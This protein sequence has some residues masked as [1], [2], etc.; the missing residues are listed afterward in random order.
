MN[1]NIKFSIIIPNYNGVQFIESCLKSLTKSLTLAKTDYE[2]IIIDNDSKD[3]SISKINELRNSLK[4]KNCKLKINQ[5]NMGFA[6]AVNQGIKAAKFD[7]ILLC[8]NDLTVDKNYFSLL[9]DAI[10][11]YPDYTTYVGT[12]LNKEGTHFESQGLKFYYSGKCDNILNQTQIIK[13]KINQSP[14]EIWGA[15]AALVTYKKNIIKKIG[16]FDENFFAYEEDVDLAL[17]LHKQGYKTLLIPKALC[18]HLGGGTS[19]KMG[20]FRHKMDFKNWIFL[21]IK[22]YSSKELLFNLFPIIEQRLRNL[23]GLIKNTPKGQKL[24]S[25][26]WV[27]KELKK[28]IPKMVKYSHDYRH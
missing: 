19:G 10:K 13:S 5:V 18:Y 27:F 26:S 15:S 7:Y 12:V 4:I 8:N 11:K 21:I 23:S 9:I 16:M 28:N 6:P 2:I 17:R 24:S 22:N 25:L 14:Y 20:N 1:N 3:N